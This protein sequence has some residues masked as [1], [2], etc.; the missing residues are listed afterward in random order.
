MCFVDFTLCFP[1][2]FSEISIYLSEI[3]VRHSLCPAFESHEWVSRSAHLK[4]VTTLA[5][6]GYVSAF[7]H[8]TP[9][10]LPLSRHLPTWFAPNC[11]RTSANSLHAI[12]LISIPVRRQPRTK[13]ID[14]N[15]YPAANKPSLLRLHLRL[16]YCFVYN[17]THTRYEL[18]YSWR[19]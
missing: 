6:R 7:F 10:L 16:V 8:P 4:Q 17:F 12:S 14:G 15:R 9:S 11:S 2:V 18:R 19:R 3:H 5:L 13:V 1:N